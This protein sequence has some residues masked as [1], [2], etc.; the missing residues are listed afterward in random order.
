MIGDG[1]AS[2][3]GRGSQGNNSRGG[4]LWWEEDEALLEAGLSVASVGSPQRSPAA[5]MRFG[6]Y[7]SISNLMP[8]VVNKQLMLRLERESV[9]L[10]PGHRV[11]VEW[12]WLPLC[13]FGGAGAGGGNSPRRSSAL[14]GRPLPA[15]TVQQ[16]LISTWDGT[17]VGNG[18]R[19]GSDHRDFYYPCRSGHR[20][21]GEENTA[22]HTSDPGPTA[23]VA[24]GA[25]CFATSTVVRAA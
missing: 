25:T 22:L 23:A 10:W 1:A 8:R 4:G 14:A 5:T 21:S 12:R 3:V 17:Q 15:L 9:L 18:G 24:P 19:T 20:E 6:E 13:W 2:G 7:Y 11:S 16:Q